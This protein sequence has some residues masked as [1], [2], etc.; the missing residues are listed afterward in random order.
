MIN[1]KELFEKILSEN[2]PTFSFGQKVKTN[3]GIGYVVG[4]VFNERLKNWKYTIRPHGLNN[5]YVDVTSI[6]NFVE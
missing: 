6:E 3:M 2:P 4:Y 5:Y 1:N